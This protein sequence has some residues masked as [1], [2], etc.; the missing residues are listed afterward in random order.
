ME[1]MLAQVVENL[2]AIQEKLDQFNDQVKLDQSNDQMAI[3]QVTES[4]GVLKTGLGDFCKHYYFS[5]PDQIV[6][7][8]E[9]D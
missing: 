8:E 7:Y 5:H 4:L 9:D 2:A 3:E 6:E 1:T